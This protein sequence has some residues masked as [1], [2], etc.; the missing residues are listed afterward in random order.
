LI[1]PLGV[2]QRPDIG[3]AEKGGDIGPVDAGAVQGEILVEDR[4]AAAVVGGVVGV[5]ELQRTGFTAD[6][7]DDGA[8]LRG[9][10]AMGRIGSKRERILNSKNAVVDRSQTTI[11]VAADM[12]G[13]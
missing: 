8:A 10:A 2:V 5:K 4:E 3:S 9:T 11:G 13:K 1:I 12:A 6:L 7:V